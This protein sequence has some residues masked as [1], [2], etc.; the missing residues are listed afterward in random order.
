MDALKIDTRSRLKIQSFDDGELAHISVSTDIEPPS[1]MN[2]CEI[3]CTVNEHDVRALRD[4]CDAFLKN[5]EGG[6]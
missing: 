2:W 3:G 4:W 1:G 6:R 5:L